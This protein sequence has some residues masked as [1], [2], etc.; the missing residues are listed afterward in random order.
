MAN[1]DQSTRLLVDSLKQVITLS[2][3]AFIL[4]A[5]LIDRVFSGDLDWKILLW[6]SWALFGLSI[7]SGLFLL[8]VL[9]DNVSELEKEPSSEKVSPSQ[10]GNALLYRALNF[11]PFIAGLVLLA[12]FVFVNTGAETPSA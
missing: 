7:A 6:G 9:I 4:S 2:A 11:Y 12:A 1:T 8:G 3:G 10:Q 5:T